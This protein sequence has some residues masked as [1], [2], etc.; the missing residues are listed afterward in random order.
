[1]EPPWMPHRSNISEFL[2][3]NHQTGAAAPPATV[4]PSLPASGRLG[5]VEFNPEREAPPGPANPNPNPDPQPHSAAQPGYTSCLR[6]IDDLL[7]KLS[8]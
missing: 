1:M 7:L 4:E 6:K 3:C 2:L 5:F 8:S